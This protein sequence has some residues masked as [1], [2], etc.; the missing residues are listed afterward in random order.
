MRPRWDLCPTSPANDASKCDDRQLSRAPRQSSFIGLSTILLS[1]SFRARA[2]TRLA[3]HNVSIVVLVGRVAPFPPQEVY[4]AKRPG[5]V[6]TIDC[7]SAVLM[8]YVFT[9]AGA[10]VVLLNAVD[11]RKRCMACSPRAAQKKSSTWAQS[12]THS[13]PESSVRKYSADRI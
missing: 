2:T 6:P 9:A 7:Y 1:A 13:D 10:E 11:R 8:L 4:W 12:A 3:S 5:I